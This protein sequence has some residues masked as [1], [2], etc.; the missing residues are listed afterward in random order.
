MPLYNEVVWVKLGHYRWWPARV[1]HPAEVPVNVERSAH[2][3]G[4]FP[5]KFCGSNDY[6][7]INHGRCFLYEEGDEERT[8]ADQKATSKASYIR[9]V[10]CKISFSAGSF[11]QV[12]IPI[13]CHICL[14]KLR[15]P[16]LARCVRRNY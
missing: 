12:V 11:S 2:A 3:M 5:I 10:L 4:E 15:W 13:I 16:H 8:R 6:Y 7:W 14:Y 1:I 9:E